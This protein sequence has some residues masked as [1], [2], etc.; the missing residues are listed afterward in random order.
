M[1]EQSSTQGQ[2]MPFSRQCRTLL[3]RQWCQIVLNLQKSSSYHDF[4]QSV[5][6]TIGQ[7]LLLLCMHSFALIS[8][9]KKMQLIYKV[10]QFPFDFSYIWFFCGCFFLNDLMF[11]WVWSGLWAFKSVQCSGHPFKNSTLKGLL[12]FVSIWEG[13]QISDSVYFRVWKY[14]LQCRFLKLKCLSRLRSIPYIQQEI[15]LLFES[16]SDMLKAFQSLLANST[17]GPDMSMKWVT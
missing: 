2:Q 16:L 9:H 15:S 3:P 1:E 14:H 17:Y 6:I 4:Y 5:L 13:C 8:A 12:V 10:R 11:C 7:F